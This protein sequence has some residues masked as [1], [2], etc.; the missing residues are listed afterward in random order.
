MDGLLHLVQQ[1]GARAGC[2]PTQSYPRCT[3]CSSLPITG[4]CTNFILFDVA[5]YLPVLIKQSTSTYVNPSDKQRTKFSESANLSQ[6]KRTRKLPNIVD[7]ETTCP[8]IGVVRASVYRELS[9]THADNCLAAR[10]C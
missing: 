4:Q 9:S 5:L 3:K 10:S 7:K 8:S 2:G 6:G 1:E